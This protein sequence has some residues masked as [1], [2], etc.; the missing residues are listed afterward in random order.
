MQQNR[1]W[2]LIGVIVANGLIWL[3]ANPLL[4]QADDRAPNGPT[5]NCVPGRSS[6]PTGVFL[7]VRGTAWVDNGPM[8]GINDTSAGTES[9]LD[10]VVVK[11]TCKNTVTGDTDTWST[12][13]GDFGMTGEYSFTVAM[14]AIPDPN[15]EF[16]LEFTPPAPGSGNYVPTWS[17]VGADDTVDSDQDGSGSVVFQTTTTSTT[18]YYDAGFTTAGY[19]AILTGTVWQEVKN[20]GLQTAE[21]LF[22][23]VSLWFDCDEL[24]SGGVSATTDFDGN[25]ALNVWL[26][27]PALT[28][29]CPLYLSHPTGWFMTTQNVGHN[30]AIDS[31]FGALGYFTSSVDIEIDNKVVTVDNDAGL[32]KSAPTSVV[33]LQ[34]I[35]VR[36]ESPLVVMGIVM[37]LVVVTVGLIRPK[38]RSKT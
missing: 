5:V 37:G 4:A 22:S 2:L 11:L 7:F 17:N 21:P 18:L 3:I 32:T 14:D 10:G 27:D 38:S 28:V 12:G 19:G 29:T 9:K 6:T 8:D 13:T 30:D 31:D 20:D 1:I 35:A 26:P 25:Y 15:W 24:I 36:A 23:N 34:E 33:A 16:E